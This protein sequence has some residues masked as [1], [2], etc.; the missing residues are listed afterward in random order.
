MALAHIGSHVVAFAAIDAF[1]CLMH[2][3][4]F[5]RSIGWSAL[6]VCL[7][8][9][10]LSCMCWFTIWKRSMLGFQ[11]SSL[12]G[13]HSG[14]LSRMVSEWNEEKWH[15]QCIEAEDDFAGL[16]MGLLISMLV[17]FYIL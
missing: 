2:A 8:A 9:L 11:E 10:V 14:E 5:N 3:D 17:R 7:A 12:H 4:P 16:T 15:E 1:G 13:V 6:C